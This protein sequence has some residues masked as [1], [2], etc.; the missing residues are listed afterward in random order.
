[1]YTCEVVTLCK[2]IV[3]SYPSLLD[4]DSNMSRELPSSRLASITNIHI[5]G[6]EKSEFRVEY[7]AMA[8]SRKEKRCA[9]RRD[10]VHVTRY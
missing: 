9:L 2:P 8:Q 1:M 7:K 4:I 5:T 3:P 10:G 6:K